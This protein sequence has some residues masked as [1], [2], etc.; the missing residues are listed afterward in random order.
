MA[1]EYGDDVPDVDY[2]IYDMNGELA[3]AAIVSGAD[4][5]SLSF[6]IEGQEEGKHLAANAT[7]VLMSVD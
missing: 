6:S 3:D 2:Y 4:F 7:Y 1:I 5:P